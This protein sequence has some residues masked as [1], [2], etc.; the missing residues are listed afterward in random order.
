[1]VRIQWSNIF[2]VGD[3]V[4]KTAGSI[5]VMLIFSIL[6]A[7]FHFIMAVYVCA[8]HPG[9]YGIKKDPLFF[10]EVFNLISFIE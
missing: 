2:S 5:G 3:P 7:A 6:G 9:K 8:V 10:L 1:M 4:Y